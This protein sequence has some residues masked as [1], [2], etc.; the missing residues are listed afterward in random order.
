MSMP[1][2]ANTTAVS[3]KTALGCS[4]KGFEMEAEFFVA[5]SSVSRKQQNLN[6]FTSL[7]FVQ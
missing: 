5:C 7:L 6:V 3:D 2:C 1:G 4:V